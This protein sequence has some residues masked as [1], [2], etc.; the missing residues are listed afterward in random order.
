[1]KIKVAAPILLLL[2]LCLGACAMGTPAEEPV[3]TMVVE[4]NTDC[5]RSYKAARDFTAAG[6][7]ELAKEHYLIALASA[8]TP[9]L[10]DALVKELD[11]VNLMIKSL[12]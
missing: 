10:Q 8:N 6:R 5:L 2:C 9:A 4:Y 12:R 7:Y 1:M 11:S 3:N